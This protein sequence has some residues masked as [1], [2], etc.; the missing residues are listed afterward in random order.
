MGLPQVVAA[1]AI[2]DLDQAHHLR[3][4]PLVEYPA[5]AAKAI[6]PVASIRQAFGFAQ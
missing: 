5:V 1:V 4:Q 6:A 3:E 2:S